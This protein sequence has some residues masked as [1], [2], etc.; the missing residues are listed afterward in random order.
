MPPKKRAGKKPQTPLDPPE[1]RAES[2]WK[3]QQ[4]QEP[5]SN[6]DRLKNGI[7]TASNHLT[8][9]WLWPLALAAPLLPALVFGFWYSLSSPDPPPIIVETPTPSPT[10]TTSTTRYTTTML[11]CWSRIDGHKGAA[12]YEKA[13]CET[14]IPAVRRY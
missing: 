8:N 5:P 14:V 4:D 1:T 12:G 9:L 10:A 7:K 3:Q 11:P 6:I 13:Y 2:A